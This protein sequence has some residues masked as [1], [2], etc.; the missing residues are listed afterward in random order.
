MD[1]KRRVRS[2]DL[3]LDWDNTSQL[4]PMVQRRKIERLKD[5]R[6]DEF[7]RACEEN[8]EW[9]EN[10]YQGCVYAALQNKD[11]NDFPSTPTNQRQPR[12]DNNDVEDMM[13]HTNLYETKTYPD[14]GT[15]NRPLNRSHQGQHSYSKMSSSQFRLKSP[16][17]PILSSPMRTPSSP[18]D[19]HRMT[20]NRTPRSPFDRRRI[21][22]KRQR[23]RVDATA[24][25]R[26]AQRTKRAMQKRTSAL[27]D[28]M[29]V[30]QH[31]DGNTLNHES[32]I[33]PTWRPSSA[34]PIQSNGSHTQALL[35]NEPRH[36]TSVLLRNDDN[37]PSQLIPLFDSETTLDN[38]FAQKTPARELKAQIQRAKAPEAD[39]R[40]RKTEEIEEAVEFRSTP[41]SKARDSMSLISPH[42]RSSISKIRDNLLSS[43]LAPGTDRSGRDVDIDI[44]IGEADY[45]RPRSSSFHDDTVPVRF[46]PSG[47]ESDTRPP[48]TSLRE[49]EP[50]LNKTSALAGNPSLIAQ[51]QRDYLMGVST[52]RS[53]ATGVGIRPPMS[54]SSTTPE[55]AP[56]AEIRVS[57]VD[58]AKELTRDFNERLIKAGVD[59]KPRLEQM[60]QMEVK[61][62]SIHRSRSILSGIVAADRPT[63]APLQERIGHS[64]T[65]AGPVRKEEGQRFSRIRPAETVNQPVP[66]SSL[67]RITQEMS[68]EKK[69]TAKLGRIDHKDAH[70]GLTNPTGTCAPSTQSNILVKSRVPQTLPEKRT[71]SSRKPTAPLSSMPSHQLSTKMPPSRLTKM[72]MSSSLA[73]APL[74]NQGSLTST[75]QQ[76]ASVSSVNKF[77]GAATSSELAD[78]RHE[79]S[80]VGPTASLLSSAS[81][82]S[83]L[84]S[85]T[86]CQGV[87]PAPLPLAKV[88]DNVLARS[89]GQ[90]PFSRR[91][92][93]TTK[94]TWTFKKPVRPA[95][96]GNSTLTT[97]S[98]ATTSSAMSSESS[99]EKERKRGVGQTDIVNKEREFTL[100][101]PLS[102]AVTAAAT[103][104]EL[105]ST[106]TVASNTTTLATTQ[107][108]S[109]DQA[110]EFQSANSSADSGGSNSFLVPTTFRLPPVSTW[111]TS[112]SQRHSNHTKTTLPDIGSDN[113]ED[114]CG[115]KDGKD[116]HGSGGPEWASFEELENAMS[117]Q[118]RLNPEDIFGPIPVLDLA[119]IFPGKE[120]RFRSRKSS[121]HWGTADRLTPQEV[122]KYNQDMGWTPKD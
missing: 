65:R 88:T 21:T 113:E 103:Y 108:V 17:T 78:H 120:T 46:G 26:K 22:P 111:A 40:S 29:D 74:F 53:T 4:W 114:K 3:D 116:K 84:A 44:E 33:G 115:D 12:F 41:G 39:S 5:E 90:N 73:M 80:A 66:G 68:T 86:L 85:N 110:M 32:T 105:A 15:R 14:C 71:I 31:S 106:G 19:R 57:R 104:K 82:A 50:H 92:L 55:H 58:S 51:D 83:P 72:N 10:Y 6:L 45:N 35:G 97:R 1:N 61:D 59:V 107:L 20:P 87:P 11:Y 75:K 96:L 112:R 93:L 100:A 13:L 42:T 102:A 64:A 27:L 49:R 62:V 121:V 37:P 98:L 36:S 76:L 47:T 43:T 118:I 9:L 25:T 79:T 122:L 101:L 95:L 52:G 99:K 23:V 38:S 70:V 18:F 63:V 91:P 16:R 8:F 77:A 119:E 69:Q 28:R 109:R 2:L 34:Q 117:D 67:E 60:G 30:E 54:H 94:P 48:D 81:S 56:E 24:A 7:Q 89:E